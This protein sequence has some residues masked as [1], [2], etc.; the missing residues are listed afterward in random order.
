[1][2]V[3]WIEADDLKDLLA[4]I[5]PEEPA[6]AT[7]PP[8]PRSW[9]H[10]PAVDPATAASFI[11]TA[12]EPFVTAEPQEIP[13]L[14]PE[15][16]VPAAREAEASPE[17]PPPE[18]APSPEAAVTEEHADHS[19]AALPLNRIRDK[20][21][22]IR[23]RAHEA[24]ML[25]KG[26]EAAAPAPQVPP[27]KTAPATP[28]GRRDALHHDGEQA[29]EVKTAPALRPAA[30]SAPGLPKFE[31][32]AGDRQERLGAFASW[33]RQILHE[34]GGH[35][36]VMNDDGELLW[37]GEAKAG[38]VLSAMMAW[39]ATLRSSASAACGSLPVLHQDLASGHALTAIPCETLTGVLLHAAVV[40]PARVPDEIAMQLRQGLIR[41]AGT[42]FD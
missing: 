26:G 41:A 27:V 11:I 25:T 32:P 29:A 42:Q 1:M 40:G 10:M 5:A 23:Q 22:A 37:G 13:P 3:S 30:S 21:R 20:L 2:Q 28:G 16:S 33:A 4:R 34:D 24:G 36:L 14:Q 8:P 35:L 12:E 7:P 17:A 6:A 19:A 38:L 39:G 9:D 31:A 18:P 15:P